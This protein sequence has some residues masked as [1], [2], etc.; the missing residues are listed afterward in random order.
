MPLSPGQVTSHWLSNYPGWLI[1]EQIRN[2]T[3]CLPTHP[4]VPYYFAELAGFYV[5]LWYWK[6]KKTTPL[7][8]C[9][10]S[11]FPFQSD[12][13][14]GTCIFIFS[15]CP[16]SNKSGPG[17][18]CTLSV[19]GP[20][21]MNTFGFGLRI[22]VTSSNELEEMFLPLLLFWKKLCKIGVQ[23]S[24]NVWWNSTVKLGLESFRSIVFTFHLKIISGAFSYELVMIIGLFRLS[25]WS[26]LSF[27]SLWPLRKDSFLLSCWKY[28]CKVVSIPIV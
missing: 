13:K 4:G 8:W 11:K 15:T 21:G 6:E 28:V 26:L 17:K 18:S 14:I 25:V 2:P 22:I 12:L 10:H 16:K 24:L 5:Q 23:S 7:R 9:L 1:T 19:S 3:L 27:S 20:V